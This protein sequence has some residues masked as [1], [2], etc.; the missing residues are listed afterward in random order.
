MVVVG[1]RPS[2]RQQ[3]EF[4]DESAEPG[5]GDSQ[6]P[7]RRVA[8]DHV[9]VTGDRVDDEGGSRARNALDDHVFVAHRCSV[10]EVVIECD[11]DL[12]RALGISDEGGS[13]V[14]RHSIREAIAQP[15]ER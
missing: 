2:P 1:T 15:G 12:A 14:R 5:G 8:A 9:G 4:A 6:H 13:W 3:R 10:K 7:R 11:R